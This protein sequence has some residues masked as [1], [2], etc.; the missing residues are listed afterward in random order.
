MQARTTN[1]HGMFEIGFEA[2]MILADLMVGNDYFA[3]PKQLMSAPNPVLIWILDFDPA[4][5]R[6]VLGIFPRIAF[7]TCRAEAGTL[8]SLLLD[9]EKR[10]A[11]L[12]AILNSFP[13]E[14]VTR[15]RPSISAI[16]AFRNASKYL[17][18]CLEAI[19]A[20]CGS[21]HELV[22]VDD[23]STDG[24]ADIARRFIQNLVT[25]SFS[26][27]P[28]FAR[29]RG[30]ES[31]RGRI[32][33]FID[34]DVICHSDTLAQVEKIFGADA[35]LA[36]IIGSYD[37]DPPAKNFI[38]LYK[39]LTHHFV[40]QN[41]SEEASTFWTGCGAIRREVF[42]ELKGFDES[43]AR[44]SIEDIELGYR[45]RSRGY[46]IAL[47][48]NLAVTHAKEWTLH[49]LLSSD[50][51]DRAIPWTILQLSYRHLLDDLNVSRIQRASSLLTCFSFFLGTC[52]ILKPILF[53]P[54]ALL[55]VPVVYWNRSLYYFYL[56]KGGIAFALGSMAMH[57]F[58]YCYSV[59]AFI[60][61]ALTFLCRPG[62][63][64]ALQGRGGTK[65]S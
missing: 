61:G 57:W 29:N 63:K 45:L 10:R 49:S 64:V 5:Q 65:Q 24:S 17:P 21:E 13:G 2:A 39:N 42:M 36:A 51:L 26:H 33:F 50:I 54:M 55:M 56:R 23:G 34:A 38:S 62:K 8:F 19:A 15:F 35:G 48:R 31:A 60:F 16:I 58:Y 43:Y 22:L 37:A 47:C 18:A 52:G 32:L 6:M 41:A 11:F 53:A 3:Y 28:A 4:C 25:L 44:P 1:V 30:A 12:Y 9:S 7:A 59:A 27:G 20:A 14:N 40:H 46:R